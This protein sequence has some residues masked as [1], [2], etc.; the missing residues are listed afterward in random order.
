MEY[1]K[2]Q[3]TNLLL[4]AF[5]Y[6][7]SNCITQ[8]I[9]VQTE[10]FRTRIRPPLNTMKLRLRCSG[11]Q[12][13]ETR[14]VNTDIIYITFPIITPFSKNT[15]LYHSSSLVVSTW[16]RE[17]IELP[18]N[19]ETSPAKSYRNASRLAMLL[20]SLLHTFYIGTI[21]VWMFLQVGHIYFVIFNLL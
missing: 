4:E 9:V 15:V 2:Q 6:L 19:T 10:M 3:E 12:P 1:T 11:L 14:S 21:T 13:A 20:I 7:Y 17:C 16:A 5:P 8:Y 18:K